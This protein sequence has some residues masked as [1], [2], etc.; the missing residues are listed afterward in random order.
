MCT[1]RFWNNFYRVVKGLTKHLIII[2]LQNREAIRK[3]VK[4]ARREAIIILLTPS[5]RLV[6]W[7]E[8][9]TVLVLSTWGKRV[10]SKSRCLFSL[11]H[12]TRNAYLYHGQ[13]KLHFNEMMIILSSSRPACCLTETTAG[14]HDTLCWFQTNQS[15]CVLPNDECLV[16]ETPNTNVVA[17]GLT[18]PGLEHTIYW[19]RGEHTTFGTTIPL[20]EN[21]HENVPLLV[22]TSRCYS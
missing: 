12:I 3:S 11:I 19:N 20:Y 13:N 2:L 14:G 15:W 17:I 1:M 6:V 18:L 22:N 16:G 21:H 9:S 10:L 4:T 5:L 7:D 8:S